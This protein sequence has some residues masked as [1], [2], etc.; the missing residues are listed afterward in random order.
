M[1]IN[2]SKAL[3]KVDIQ[4]LYSTL[5]EYRT[6][7]NIVEHFKN[8]HRNTKIVVGKEERH[9]NTGIPKRSSYSTYFI[10]IIITE[11]KFFGAGVAL[12][13]LT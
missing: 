5:E 8:I 4:K 3:N 2:F 11:K 10:I 9:I 6:T 1:L 7:K 12:V 13:S